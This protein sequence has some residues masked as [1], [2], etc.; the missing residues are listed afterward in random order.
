MNRRK[1]VEVVP[2]VVN[3]E[4]KIPDQQQRYFRVAEAANYLRI[5]TS[6]VRVAYRDGKLRGAIHGKRL[7]FSRENLDAFFASAA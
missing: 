7:I 4:T 5:T 2:S 1:T 3:P 6:L